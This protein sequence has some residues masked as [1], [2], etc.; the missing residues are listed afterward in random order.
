MQP[1]DESVSFKQS[2]PCAVSS[3]SK[4]AGRA[5]GYLNQRFH[6]YLEEFEQTAREEILSGHVPVAWRSG[7]ELVYCV[8]KATQSIAINCSGYHVLKALAHLPLLAWLQC[9]TDS[10]EGVLLDQIEAAI[11]ESADFLLQFDLAPSVVKTAMQSAFAKLEQNEI[12][13][14]GMLAVTDLHKLLIKTAARDEVKALMQAVRALQQT[15][16]DVQWQR[17]HFVVSGGS[18]ARYKELSKNFFVR[19]VLEQTGCQKQSIHRVIYAE[20]CQTLK[21]AIGLVAERLVNGRLAEVFLN[22]PISLDQD[23]LGDSALEAMDELFSGS[24]AP[25]T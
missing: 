15:V 25:E 5:L 20:D 23:V 10:S 16:D 17:T 2:Q 6:E 21:D 8:G 1:N 7:D 18:Q 4:P 22:S 24:S 9:E 3:E 14:D 12:S 19:L 11:D 13:D